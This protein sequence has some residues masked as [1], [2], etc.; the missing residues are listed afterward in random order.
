MKLY[1]LTTQDGL[2]Q[3]GQS[4]E[5]RWAEGVNT[6][7]AAPIVTNGDFGRVGTVGG[8]LNAHTA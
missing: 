8:I 5:T 2:T 7:S 6:T 4:N 3:A 1:K